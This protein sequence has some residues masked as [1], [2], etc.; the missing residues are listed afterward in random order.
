[1]NKN[2]KNAIGVCVGIVSG[3]TAMSANEND[4]IPLALVSLLILAI[5]VIVGY[6]SQGQG[7]HEKGNTSP[8]Y[9][10]PVRKP[11]R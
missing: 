8:Y 4:N 2:I 9:R 1:M 3:F 7:R 5:T 10:K 11:L 6:V